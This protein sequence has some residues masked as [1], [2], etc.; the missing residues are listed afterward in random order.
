MYIL[1]YH[2]FFQSVKSRN[3]FFV[4][5]KKKLN[6]LFYWEQQQIKVLY[7]KYILV[8]LAGGGRAVV[9]GLTILFT[10]KRSGYR[11]LRPFSSRVSCFERILSGFWHASSANDGGIV[12]KIRQKSASF[13]NFSWNQF[14]EK[15]SWKWFH[16]KIWIK[17]GFSNCQSTVCGGR[18]SLIWPRRL[19]CLS[20]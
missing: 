17:F 20:K 15:S 19:L 7:C 18:P 16:E 10:R 14:H 3:I 2:A 4:K 11:H 9:G 1:Q 12:L 13:W 5:Q 8:V 6:D